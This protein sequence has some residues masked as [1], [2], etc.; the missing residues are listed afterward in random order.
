MKLYSVKIIISVK[1]IQIKRI[2]PNK[3]SRYFF[4]SKTKV[5]YSKI[6]VIRK[7]KCIYNLREIMENI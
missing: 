2:K 7:K 6:Y 3:N 5:V 4:H 1:R